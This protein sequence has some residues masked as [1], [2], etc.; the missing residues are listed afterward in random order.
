MIK[1][2]VV[3][4][5]KISLHG[6]LEMLQWNLVR[7]VGDEWEPDFLHLGQPHGIYK[8]PRCFYLEKLKGN[9]YEISIC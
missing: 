6:Q 7:I 2:Y 5:L 1:A 3:K 8:A 9:F 4:L